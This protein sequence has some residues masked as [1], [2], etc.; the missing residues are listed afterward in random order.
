MHA[1]VPY[2]LQSGRPAMFYRNTWTDW[3][4]FWHRGYPRFMYVVM[5]GVP[6][7]I[8]L[9]SRTLSRS[10]LTMHDRRQF[11]T[12]SVR[13]LCTTLRAWCSEGGFGWQNW[14]AFDLYIHHHSSDLM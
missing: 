3:I 11:I 10:Q 9:P 1:I 7:R 12:L 8:V 14:A 2:L 5:E 6:P 13:P 4:L